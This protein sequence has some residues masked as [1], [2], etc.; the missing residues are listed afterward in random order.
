MMQL[1]WAEY[2]AIWVRW[3]SWFDGCVGR[4]QQWFGPN[5]VMKVV[6][7]QLLLKKKIT[8]SYE[9][10]HARPNLS[11]NE[12]VRPKLCC[13][14]SPLKFFSDQLPLLLSSSPT[15]PHFFSDQ[16][17]LLLQP[18]PTASPTSSYSPIASVSV[19]HTAAS[20]SNG[21]NSSSLQISFSSSSK[22]NM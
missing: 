2:G 20:P 14:Q 19:L 12:S 4:F 10:S 13:P 8:G 21:F 17:P 22:L 3:W 5:E 6:G 1:V 16:L 11:K 7:S 18:T 15:S 9:R